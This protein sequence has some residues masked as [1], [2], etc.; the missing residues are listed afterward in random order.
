[1]ANALGV[2]GLGKTFV[3]YSS[4]WKRIAGFLGWR[5]PPQETH[6][7]LRDVTFAVA[8]GEAVGLVGR[9]GAGK[10]TLLKLIA[11]TLR[12]TE[13][14]VDALGRITA[15]LELGTG[16][17]P[18]FTGRTNVTYAAGLMG[19]DSDAIASAMDGIE[20]FADI[21]EYFDR[22][23][24]TYSSG[25][26]M[27]VAF[28]V[29]TAFAPQ[30]LLVDEALAV[31]D[32]AFQAKCFD[33]IRALRE[34][35]CALLFVSHSVEE[36]VKHCDRALLVDHGRVVLDDTSRVVSNAYLDLVWGKGAR[37]HAASSGFAAYDGRDLFVTRPGYRPEEHRFGQGG[38]RIVDVHVESGGQAFASP[39][40][41]ARDLRIAMQVAFERDVESPVYGLL[42][43]THDGVFLYG[44][45]SSI[46]NGPAPGVRAGDVVACEFAIPSGL[47]SGSYLVSL[48]VSESAPGGELVPLDRRYDSLLLQAVNDDPVWGLVDLRATCR[49]ESGSA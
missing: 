33:R 1:M 49:I 21:G 25:M 11:G 26:Q 17:N 16:F 27:R 36:V 14:R 20:A 19:I 4:E 24:R 18:E 22:P 9:N 15:I 10:S 44:T 8:P 29:A 41:A 47:N 40:N 31:G 32:V 2:Q 12:P 35:G 5:M 13:G 6:W 30:V 39:V 28:A 34:G 37:G 42:I 43:K 45:N 3:R 38:A 48:G 23:A 7:A 46:A